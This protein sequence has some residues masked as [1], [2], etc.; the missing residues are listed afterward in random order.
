MRQLG[1]AT[2]EGTSRL[3]KVHGLG[4]QDTSIGHT[5]ARCN[6]ET[7]GVAA[8]Q[9][10]QL[11]ADPWVTTEDNDLPRT[12][13]PARIPHQEAPDLELCATQEQPGQPTRGELAD[14]Q[15]CATL[16]GAL[17]MIVAPHANTQPPGC[18]APSPGDAVAGPHGPS[19]LGSPLPLPALPSG[20]GV[21]FH[22]L[23]MAMLEMGPQAQGQDGREGVG[24]PQPVMGDPE[25]ATGA[26]TSI[27]VDDIPLGG[28]QA[29]GTPAS[30]RKLLPPPQRPL[31]G[32]RAS[33]VTHKQHQ[34]QQHEDQSR[35]GVLSRLV[36]SL[37]SATR[38]PSG[39]GTSAAAAAGAGAT[40]PAP[41]A[42]EGTVSPAR[43]PHTSCPAAA[44]SHQLWGVATHGSPRSR[45]SSSAGL[46]APQGSLS[47]EQGASPGS[48]TLG[49]GRLQNRTSG[50][51]PLRVAVLEAP[52]PGSPRMQL[53]SGEGSEQLRSRNTAVRLVLMPAGNAVRNG[54]ASSQGSPAANSQLA[55]KRTASGEEHLD[56]GTVMDNP[57]A[58]GAGVRGSACVSGDSGSLPL[59]HVTQQM[60]CVGSYESLASAALGRAGS[61]VGARSVPGDGERKDGGGQELVGS[62]GVA[63]RA[64]DAPML[65]EVR[66]EL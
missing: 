27:G 53:A 58:A 52:A 37:R 54:R 42:E 50:G 43:P 28:P 24:L 34:Y 10:R 18:A 65:D 8:P 40:S 14:D 49:Q 36:C 29:E 25:H 55:P 26:S 11:L 2:P 63:P 33:D 45:L 57:A 64:P 32:A 15:R 13:G 19:R 7:V 66:Q 12:R 35:S 38:G 47:T 39:A 60:P 9:Q 3:C 22:A 46:A 1:S 31:S 41:S 6:S 51:K 16:R 61:R 20:T 21:G 56:A 44:T 48:A 4:G 23:S 59:R 5:G 30:D 17:A 62:L